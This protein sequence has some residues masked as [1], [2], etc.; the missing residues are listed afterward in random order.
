MLVDGRIRIVLDPGLYK[1][2]LRIRDILGRIRIRGSIPLTNGSGFRIKKSQNS[3]NQ[4][5][6]YYFCLM[7]EGSGFVPLTN[8][9]GYRSGRPKNIQSRIRNTGTTN[10]EFGS[11]RPKNKRILRIRI[12]N[13]G[14]MYLPY[15]QTDSTGTRVDIVFVVMPN[16]SLHFLKKRK[17]VRIRKI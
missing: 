8:G 2:L 10:D 15:L 7:I 1:P 14:M 6:S 12:H 17:K 5:F 13:T 9:S 16:Y 3:R 4:G 11:A